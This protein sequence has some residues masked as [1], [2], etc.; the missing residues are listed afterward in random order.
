LDR[1]YTM[2]LLAPTPGEAILDAAC[3]TPLCGIA[4][5]LPGVIGIRAGSLDDPSWYRPALDVY[6]ASAQPWDSMN[7]TLPK[8]PKLP[9]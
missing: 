7:P 8:F 9:E 4:I 2:D 1:R 5:R 6:T 3:G